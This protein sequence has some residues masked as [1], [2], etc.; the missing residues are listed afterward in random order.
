MCVC[1]C[2]Y[3]RPELCVNNHGP[4]MVKVTECSDL[5]KHNPSDSGHK[6]PSITGKP[7]QLVALC[8]CSFQGWG[9]TAPQG[10]DKNMVIIHL[11]PVHKPFSPFTFLYTFL[12]SS[13]SASLHLSLSVTL[14]HFRT[15]RKTMHSCSKRRLTR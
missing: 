15:N 14:L 8:C 13:F 7:R 5:Q 1:V 4:E 3:D 2:V 12:F 11:H 6:F 9:L 10:T